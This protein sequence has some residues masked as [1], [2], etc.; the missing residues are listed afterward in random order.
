MNRGSVKYFL[1]VRQPWCLCAEEGKYTGPLFLFSKTGIH[2]YTSDTRGRA[3]LG[4]AFGRIQSIQKESIASIYLKGNL[5]EDS[6]E[7]KQIV[8]YPFGFNS[9]Q[10]KAVNYALNNRISVIE[11]P[12][13]TGKTQTI[14]NILANIVMQDGTAAVVSS[15]NSATENVEEKLKKY[16]VDFISAFLGSRKNKRRIYSAAERNSSHGRLENSG[17]RESRYKTTAVTDV[18][19]L[20]KQLK[21]RE[22][23]AQLSAEWNTLKVEQAHF[24]TYYQETCG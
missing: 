12:P 9:S 1:L 10:K 5:P 3:I 18:R 23:M 4:K 17:S 21:Q 22:R 19:S 15:N 13:G 24:L 16:E 8:Y 7:K 6:E 14:L 20:D 11:G 2:R